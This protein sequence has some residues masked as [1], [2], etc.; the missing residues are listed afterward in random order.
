MNIDDRAELLGGIKL[1]AP[2]EVFGAI[3]GLTRSVLTPADVRA[4]A[5]RLGVTA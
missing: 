4:V 5:A 1:R 3:W 2:A